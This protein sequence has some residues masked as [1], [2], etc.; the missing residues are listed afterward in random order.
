VGVLRGGR[1]CWLIRCKW[2]GLG[3]L[4]LVLTLSSGFCQGSHLA[5]P[6]DWGG[7]ATVTPALGPNRGP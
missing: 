7:R 5:G 6:L 3:C 2:A 4:E 1:H